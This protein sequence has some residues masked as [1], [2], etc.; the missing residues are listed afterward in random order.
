ML[1]FLFYLPAILALLWE[2][3]HITSPIKM[4]ERKNRL[5][6]AG[7]TMTKSQMT[8]TFLVLSYMAWCLIGLFSSQWVLFAGMLLFSFIP[9]R[10]AIVVFLDAVISFCLV[11]F[12]IINAFH[13]HIPVHEVV[14]NWLKSLI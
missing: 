13:L 3:I 7:K 11:G 4:L 6:N 2:A 14:F 5:M 10:H 8:V 12:I 1:K 9:K